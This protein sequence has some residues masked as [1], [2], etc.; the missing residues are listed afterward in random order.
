MLRVARLLSWLAIL[1]PRKMIT[2]YAVTLVLLGLRNDKYNSARG[3]HHPRLLGQNCK[4]QSAPSSN[5][6]CA[7][8]DSTD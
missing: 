7:D 5:Y 6:A 2:M 4:E 8:Y 1:V 3:N